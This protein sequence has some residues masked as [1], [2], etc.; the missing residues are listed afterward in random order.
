MGGAILLESSVA[1]FQQSKKVKIHTGAGSFGYKEIG[2]QLEFGTPKWNIQWNSYYQNTKNNFPYTYQN[3]NYKLSNAN[4]TAIGSLLNFSYQLNTKKRFQ[5]HYINLQAW[6]QGNNRA[7]P[8]AFFEQKSTKLQND[9]SLRSLIHWHLRHKYNECNIK[10]SFIQEKAVYNDT[11]VQLFNHYHSQSVFGSLQWKYFVNINPQ[12]GTHKFQVILPFD[13]TTLQN[14]QANI[15]TRQIK[16]AVAFQYDWIHPKKWLHLQGA[17]RKDWVIDRASIPLSPSLSSSINLFNYHEA[18]KVQWTAA[19]QKTYRVP[20]LNELYYFPGG[21]TQLLPEYGWNRQSGFSST[22]KNNLFNTN[23]GIDYFNRSIHNWI[24][25]LGGAIWT[26]YNISKVQSS[27]F[28]F[29]FKHHHNVS[30]SVQ[31]LVQMSYSNTIAQTIEALLPNDKSIGKQI[32]YVPKHNF[33]NNLSFIWK[34]FVLNY[35]HTYTG[36][37]YI[38]IDES[39]YLNPFYLGNMHLNYTFQLGVSKIMLNGAIQNIWNKDY[40]VIANRPMPGRSFALQCSVEL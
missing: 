33:Q 12:W 7:I 24:Y 37:R 39:M 21:N 29:Y 26:P 25:W 36:Y 5:A 31:V 4:A 28:E 13:Y 34:N 40:Q 35:N 17:I 9:N 10:L 15:N 3:N 16:H 11:L 18:W 6:W 8:P 20:T 27:G 38:T 19:I 1:K 22:F 23:V 2:K 14:P 32:P 30:P